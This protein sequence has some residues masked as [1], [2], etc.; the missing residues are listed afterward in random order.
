MRAV[1]VVVLGL[2]ACSTKPNPNRC[3]TDTAD[4]EA[5]GI[6][7]VT[8]CGD[9]LVCR[10]H[11]CIAETCTSSA[12]CD[13]SAPFCVD[14]SCSATCTTDDQCPGNG[15][16]PAL[17]HCVDGAC[18][19][20]REDAAD[21]PVSAPVCDMGACR[22]CTADTECGS[23]VCDVDAG[24]CIDETTLLYVSPSGD[25]S[26]D[27]SKASP[28]TLARAFGLADASRANI[29]L[30]TGTYGDAPE[31]RGTYAL[32][33]FGPATVNRFGVGG[34]G[35]ILRLRDLSLTYSAGCS[36]TST[37]GP[38]TQLD[39]RRVAINY[40]L[41]AGPV[42]SA[43]NCDVKL[44]DVKVVVPRTD[45][46][47]QT[48]SFDNAT[49]D[50]QNIIVDGGDPAISLFD[51]ATVSVRNSIFTNQGPSFGILQF[52]QSGGLYHESGTFEFSTFYNTTVTCPANAPALVTF[53]NNVFLNARGGAP[54]NTV[55]GAGC[56]HTYDMIKPQSA[57]PGSTNLLNMDP[58]FVNAANGDFHLMTGSPA[59]DAADP[60]ATLST[61]YD[62]VSRPQGA[63]R[64]LGAFEYKP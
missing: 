50:I 57:S 32:T 1:L 39:L 24:T 18:V 62:G 11:Q 55:S 58:R 60:A 33:V 48:L 51:M 23:G 64:D 59:I 22:G 61:D 46:A 44:R 6:S 54:T 45:N 12:Q 7:E 21:C 40:D 29:K 38:R 10:G 4:C 63:G 43:G 28:C 13:L 31:F 36:V 47:G 52:A 30:A 49:A 42:I 2:V 56:V 14:S 34:N 5:A 26:S 16:D 8:P 15:G 41:V 25:A 27:C 20:C 3:C 37:V 53:S 19:A 17:V 9:D 35:G